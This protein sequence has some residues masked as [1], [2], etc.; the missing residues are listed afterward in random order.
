[1]TDIPKQV[2]Y[3]VKSA[4]QDF[5]AG[6]YLIQAE[7]T[8]HGLFFIHLALEKMLKACFCKN[9]NQ[10]PP[11]IHNLLRLAELAGI[12]LDKQQQDNLTEINGFNLEGRYPLDFIKPLDKNEAVKY[13]TK[14]QEEFKCFRQML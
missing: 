14:A 1:M 9:Q 2:E 3:W 12:K 10:T 7:K 11:K 6:G 4:E 8:R 13:M 5:D